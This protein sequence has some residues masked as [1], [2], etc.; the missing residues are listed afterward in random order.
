MNIFLDA[1]NMRINTK[2]QRIIP[3]PIDPVNPI[4]PFSCGAAE[5]KSIVRLF[6]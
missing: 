3:E 6:C 4:N 5:G 1:S 2:E